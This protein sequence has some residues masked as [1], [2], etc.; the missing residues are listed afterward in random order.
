MATHHV[1]VALVVA[2]VTALVPVEASGQHDTALE[3]LGV[4]HFE[5]SCREN[6]QAQFNHAVALLHHMT[7]S[8]ARAEFSAIASADPECAMAHWG[9][10]MTYFQPLWPTRPSADDLEHGWQEVLRAEASGA[11]T[12]RDTMFI[13]TTAAFFDPA[14]NGYWERIA[15]WAEATRALYEA[16]PQEVETKAFF[17][18]SVL[19]T[20]PSTGGLTHQNEAAAVLQAILAVEPMHPGAVHY[21]IHANDAVGR[22]TESLDVVRRYVEI[23]PRNPHALHMPTHIYVRLGDWASV[24]DGNRQAA[25][26]ALETPAGDR[27][28]WVWDEFPH[29]IEYLVYALLQVG[30]DSAAAMAM[31]RLQQ[32]TNLQPSFK[33]AFHL[34]S[35]PARYALERRDW[36]Q[37]SRLTPRP[38]STLTWDLFPWPEAVTWFARG[39]GAIRTRNVPAA[40]EAQRHLSALRDASQR[41]GED[42]FARQTEILRLSV[43]A[44]LAEAAANTDSALALM[45]QAVR[46]E[47]STPKPP[48]TPAPILPAS[49]LLGDLL[50]ELDRPA[51][52]LQAYEAALKSEPG[53]FNSLAGAARSAGR[54]GDTSLARTYYRELLRLAAKQSRR[55]ELAEAAA[56]LKQKEVAE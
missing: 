16:Y 22:E 21:M 26:A 23:A 48:V 19:A 7:Y 5:I 33:T 11:G 51:A 50:L 17:A 49:E 37:A 34:S 56:F 18:L 53:R 35:I 36:T 40:Q 52:A 32:T 10:A 28:Q 1:I 6:T 29:T 30:D 3:H 20:A 47:A 14:V 9:I 44:W 24:I 15:K 4:V 25:D 13:A 12:R 54:A 2:T 45:Q 39:I 41:M 31:A 43:A 8:R 55:P 27:Q 38:D 46:L 42:L